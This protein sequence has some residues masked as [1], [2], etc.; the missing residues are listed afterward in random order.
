MDEKI[1]YIRPI[2]D[3]ATMVGKRIVHPGHA[4]I[5]ISQKEFDGDLHNIEVLIKN[6]T[7]A[8]D[9]PDD[10]T[11]P[12][13]AKKYKADQERLEKLFVGGGEVPPPPVQVNLGLQRDIEKEAEAAELKA[14]S[15]TKKCIAITK[16]TGKQCGHNATEG[17]LCGIHFNAVNEGKEVM[18]IYGSI[19]EIKDDSI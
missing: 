9:M 4:P 3:R 2:S 19:I 14:A 13:S 18:D 12:V 1:Y 16:R 7:I 15:L 6:G 11:Y 10:K 5:P 8:I 17:D